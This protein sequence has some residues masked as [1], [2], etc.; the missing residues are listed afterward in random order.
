MLTGPSAAALYGSDAANGVVVINTKRGVK[1]RTVVTVSN[2]TT[3]SKVYRR[4]HAEQLRNQF[5]A[6]ELG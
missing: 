4:R 5:G 1:D 6:D 2:S 3:F